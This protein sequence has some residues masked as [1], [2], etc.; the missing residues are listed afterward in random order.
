MSKPS[1][2]VIPGSF[3]LPEFYD[4]VVDPVKAKGY[5]IR[6]LHL[7]TVGLGP[8]KPREGT[9]PTMYDDAAFIAKEVEKLADEGKDVILIAHSYG[10][11]PVTESVKGLSKEERAKAGKKGGVV[12]I[13]YMTCL[14]PE[15]GQNAMGILGTVKSEHKVQFR[16][17]VRSPPHSTTIYPSKIKTGIRLAPPRRYPTLRIH[18]FQRYLCSRRPSLDPKNALSF[19]NQLQQ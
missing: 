4:A 18:L 8:G 19:S 1:I 16:P 15:V 5:D 3:A 17:D 7:P 11:I 9:P 10:G 6:A 14:V 2:L 13:A 12:R